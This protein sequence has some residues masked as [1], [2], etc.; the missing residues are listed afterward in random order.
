MYL[1]GEGFQSTDDIKTVHTNLSKQQNQTII[2]NKREDPR[3][4]VWY[5][6]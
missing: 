4:V 2:T 3:P 6:L 5:Q 1:S